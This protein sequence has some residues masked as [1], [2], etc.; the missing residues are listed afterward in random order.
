MKIVKSTPQIEK[1]QHKVYISLE[2]FVFCPTD[3]Q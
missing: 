1:Q 2:S 3:K